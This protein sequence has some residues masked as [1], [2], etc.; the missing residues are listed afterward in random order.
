MDG[1]IRSKRFLTLQLLGYF[2]GGLIPVFFF[3]IKNYFSGDGVSD[4]L[5]GFFTLFALLLSL[6]QSI[7]IYLFVEKSDAFQ[8]MFNGQSLLTYL[9][10]HLLIIYSGGV[11]YSPLSFEYVYIV[12]VVGYIYGKRSNNLVQA[13]LFSCCSLVV[14]I[15][16]VSPQITFL[17]DYLF[18]GNKHTLV[19]MGNNPW[20]YVFVYGIQIVVAIIILSIKGLRH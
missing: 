2:V 10:L 12:G 1:D 4:E 7:T 9:F 3:L 16:Y 20:I 5:I 17:N 19:S 14:N 8:Q 13:V 15:F 6:W 11:K 18:N